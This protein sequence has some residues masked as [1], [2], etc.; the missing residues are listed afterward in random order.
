[1]KNIDERVIEGFGEEWSS[2][3][4]SGLSQKE[5]DKILASFITPQK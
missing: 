5:L 4:Q 1:M 2:Y 3:D